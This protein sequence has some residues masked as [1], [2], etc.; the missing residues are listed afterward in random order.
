MSILKAKQFFESL[1]NT[2]QPG[3]CVQ[4]PKGVLGTVEVNNS[5]FV[6]NPGYSIQRDN[7]VDSHT[8][9]DS[10]E[11]DI[12]DHVQD[13]CL[14]NADDKIANLNA[15]K[16]WKRTGNNGEDSDD[17]KSVKLLKVFYMLS[18]RFRIVMCLYEYSHL[19]TNIHRMF[20]RNVQKM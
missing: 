10:S 9:T 11:A 1:A 13:H 6:R 12:P 20:V 15:H 7:C 19:P 18:M 8:H 4:S 16:H 3:T 14:S 5:V 17:Y 2:T